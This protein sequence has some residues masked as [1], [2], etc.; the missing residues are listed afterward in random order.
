MN[1][2]IQILYKFKHLYYCIKFK[3]QFKKWLWELVR[4]PKII[5]KYHPSYLEKHLT[6]EAS[7]DKVLEQWIGND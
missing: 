2:K 4:E 7:I 1:I 5:L 3:T 6:D